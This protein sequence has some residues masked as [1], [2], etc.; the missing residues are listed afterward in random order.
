MPFQWVLTILFI[1]FDESNSAT[2]WTNIQI[3]IEIEG[4]EKRLPFLC[5]EHVG[6]IEAA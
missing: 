1:E 6:V 2:V 3:G 5:L 4:F